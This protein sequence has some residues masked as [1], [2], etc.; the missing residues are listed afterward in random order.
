MELLALSE[1][2][3]TSQ[4]SGPSAG[5]DSQGFLPLQRHDLDEPHMGRGVKPAPG[6]LSGF[7]NPS[8]VS[9][10]AQASRPC[11]VPQPF[12]GFSPSEGSP[13]ENRAPLSGP[14][15]PLWLST[16]ELDALL[17]SLSPRVSPTPTLSRSCLDPHA[18]MAS[19]ST[20]FPDTS[21]SRSPLPHPSDALP[22]RPGSRAA[23]P[24]R[25][26]NFTHFGALI[27]PRV[28]SHRH[29]LPRDDGRSSPGFLPL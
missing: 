14:H 13:R 22:G 23:E 9:R 27:L 7:L 15:A 11:F 2:V 8:A 3:S 19:L 5:S 12:L 20:R 4:P 6:P 18:T 29:G 16:G 21:T 17:E 25:P 28:R 10:Q 24:P 1:L 26:A